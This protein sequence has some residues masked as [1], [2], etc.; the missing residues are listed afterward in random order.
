MKIIAYELKLDLSH[1]PKRP[2]R[3]DVEKYDALLYPDDCLEFLDFIKI[4]PYSGKKP[5]D[6]LGWTDRLSKTDYPRNIP[7]ICL[8]S[9]R[10]LQILSDVGNFNYEAI[11]TRI[12]D[13]RL[14][15]EIDEYIKH[16][17]LN[18]DICNQSYLAVHLLEHI[19]VM[20]R[21][22]SEFEYSA[23][24]PNIPPSVIKLAIKETT[25]GFPPLFRICDDPT[26]L[27][28]SPTAKEALEN[29]KI[30]G[31]QFLPYG[32]DGIAISDRIDRVLERID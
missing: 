2:K 8:M 1:I 12:F 21:E 24:N 20:D 27:F 9:S 26:W 11:P 13:Y 23:V 22:K 15:Y 17:N 29:S 14:E 3:G 7:H 30:Q 6:F 28:I 10:M 32:S 16:P 4:E 31:I 5:I 25:G 18:S 19:D